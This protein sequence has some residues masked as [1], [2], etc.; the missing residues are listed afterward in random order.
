MSFHFVL[1]RSG[2]GYEDLYEA[3]KTGKKTSEWRDASDHWIKRLLNERG[4]IALEGFKSGYE[5][6]DSAGARARF[7]MSHLKYT[8]ARFVTG[9]V[10]T[11]MLTA[12]VKA[13]IYH[14]D[15]DQ[16]E[17]Q[18]ENVRERRK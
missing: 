7:L 14:R 3:I 9:Y 1:Q 4:Q 15:T 17:V 11:P 5:K 13:I 16:F 6:I 10:K 18:I 12:T 8:R 2:W